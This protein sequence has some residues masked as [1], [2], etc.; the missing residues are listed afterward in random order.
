MLAANGELTPLNG[1]NFALGMAF[2]TGDMTSRAI[3]N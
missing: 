1:S 2:I 3:S